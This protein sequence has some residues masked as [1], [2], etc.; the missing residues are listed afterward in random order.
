MRGSCTCGLCSIETLARVAEGLRAVPQ[1]RK[2]IL[3]ISPGLRVD[4]TMGEFVQLPAS[5]SAYHDT[6]EARKH[7]AMLDV[8]RQ[9]QLANVTI[10]AIDPNGL[11]AGS[12]HSYPEF[13]RTIADNTG[14][15]AI[16]NDNEPERHVRA[17]LLE[18]SSYYLLGFESANTTVR[19]GY[20]RIQVRVD[21]RDVDVRA[22]GGY[23]E[24]TAKDRKAA[25]SA[26]RRELLMRRS[27]ASCRSRI[28]RCRPASR[29]SSTAIAR[30]PSRLRFA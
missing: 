15:R 11:P 10:S 26:A 14:G 29:H 7:D 25:V 30:R 8:F 9:A 16:V 28:C 5:F 21:G 17:L 24:P 19:G 3:Y 12:G 4:T 6:C 20:H 2:T 27:A 1:R 22:R 13:L 23:Y 18:S